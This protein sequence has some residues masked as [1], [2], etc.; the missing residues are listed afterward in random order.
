MPPTPR[1]CD[2][3]AA[4]DNNNTTTDSR[5]ESDID[6]RRC[7][8]RMLSERVFLD[9]DNCTDIPVFPTLRTT[10]FYGNGNSNQR[11]TKKFK[12]RPSGFGGEA[13]DDDIPIFSLSLHRMFERELELDCTTAEDTN[14]TPES[15]N[16]PH[17]IPGISI[18][19]PIPATPT[20]TTTSSFDE[21][22]RIL[23]S[24]RLSLSSSTLGSGSGSA[25]IT[26]M[27]KPRLSRTGLPLSTQVRRRSSG[28]ARCA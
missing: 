8:K 11:S 28:I 26:T 22:Q 5:D 27:L 20:P 4:D 18:E 3:I 13:M 9:L 10:N 17:R 25:G 24:L 2:F 15:T 19:I 7:C 1:G 12:A 6:R 21:S 23:D 16:N 14:T